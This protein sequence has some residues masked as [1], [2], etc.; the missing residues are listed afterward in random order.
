MNETI[1]SYADLAITLPHPHGSSHPCLVCADA[2]AAIGHA[3]LTPVL[4]PRRRSQ[5]T[6]RLQAASRIGVSYAAYCEHADNG[7]RWCSGHRDWH[8]SG[9]FT[10]GNTGTYCRAWQNAYSGRAYA[11]R[12]V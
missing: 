11:R 1:A 8:P 4:F 2:R 7:E 5:E 6:R 10:L 9:Q 12:A 3:P